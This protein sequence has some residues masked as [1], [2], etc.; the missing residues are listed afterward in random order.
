M[1]DLTVVSVGV[2]VPLRPCH[3]WSAEDESEHHGDEE[4]N[5]V[6]HY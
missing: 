5:L 3:S 1:M 6:A 4:E 2:S